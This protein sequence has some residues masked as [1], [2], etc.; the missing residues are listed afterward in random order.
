MLVPSVLSSVTLGLVLCATVTLASPNVRRVADVQERTN[1]AAHE[2]ILE[3]RARAAKKGRPK[4]PPAPLARAA[5]KDKK[6]GE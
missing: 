4:A 5:K 2:K 6:P 1:M 3:A